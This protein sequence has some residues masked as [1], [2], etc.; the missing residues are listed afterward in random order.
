MFDILSPKKKSIADQEYQNE[1]IYMQIYT[2][3]KKTWTVFKVYLLAIVSLFRIKKNVNEHDSTK[4]NDFKTVWNLIWPFSS[5]F[6]VIAMESA[7]KHQHKIYMKRKYLCCTLDYCQEMDATW[8][9]LIF[10]VFIFS[11]FFAVFFTLI[12]LS[13]G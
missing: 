11:F 2:V 12:L 7:V 10:S 8:L 6:N 1:S 9:F 4:K 3:I 13:G 5:T